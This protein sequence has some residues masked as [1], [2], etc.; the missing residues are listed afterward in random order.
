MKMMN[1]EGLILKHIEMGQVD[2][3][4][5]QVDFNDE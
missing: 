3:N 5:E 4:D 1:E 2:Y